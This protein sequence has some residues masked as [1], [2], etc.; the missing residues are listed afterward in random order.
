MICRDEAWK[1]L[2]GRVDYGKDIFVQDYDSNYTRCE[3]LMA[4]FTRALISR[5][6]LGLVFA[7]LDDDQ[8]L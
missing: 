7:E 1:E 8:G 6:P 4:A 2:M 5:V 3:L